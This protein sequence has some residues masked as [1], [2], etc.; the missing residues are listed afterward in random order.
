MQTAVAPLRR[1][2]PLLATLAISALA[3]AAR[4]DAYVYFGNYGTGSVGRFNQN[5]PS[6]GTLRFHPERVGLDSGVAVDSTYIYW[7]DLETGRIGRA[8]LDGT[9]VNPN[10][11]P[12]S[13]LPAAVAVNGR[14]IYWTDQI[15][16]KRSD[17]C[18]S[19]A[20]PA[21]STRASS[22]SPAP[23]SRESR[24][25]TSTSTGRKGN[26]DD[27]RRDRTR[28]PRR[29]G[30]RPEL[31]HGHRPRR[32]LQTGS[33]STPSTSIGRTAARSPGRVRSAARTSTAVGSSWAS[34]PP[35]DPIGVAVDATHIYWANSPEDPDGTLR[36]ALGRANLDGTQADP[37]WFEYGLGSE[38]CCATQ[39]AI[40]ALPATCAGSDA[41]I[42]G[43]RQA[44][45]LRG[46]KDDDVI[47][48]GRG[49]DTVT[50]LEG[51]DLVCGA[52]GDD[53]LRGQGGD[54]D[55]RGGAGDDDLRG[56]GGSNKCRGGAGTDSKQGC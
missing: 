44:D 26:P 5:Y 46:T 54:D 29:Q 49:D 8:T 35:P 10:F 34:S 45:R 37:L 56:G 21:A 32:P 7:T 17:A 51:D 48:A 1:A 31:H 11:I 23:T 52:R 16:R 6:G 33:R 53:V 24:S 27:T 4:A 19:T 13:R 43:T 38:F 25:T 36:P 20:I 18:V 22:P 9:N 3:L 42:A 39:L 50:G 12:P 28:Q 47:A 30:R 2:A 14:F 15:V 41:T 55:L 40:N